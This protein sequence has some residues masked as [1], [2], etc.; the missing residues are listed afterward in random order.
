MVRLSTL[1]VGAGSGETKAPGPE[2]ET[3]SENAW[4][5]STTMATSCTAP[6]GA[7]ENGARKVWVPTSLTPE[8]PLGKPKVQEFAPE[9][10]TVSVAPVLQL[11]GLTEVLLPVVFT[12]T[13]KVTVE[14]GSK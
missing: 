7:E 13:T 11:I 3:V 14:P 9:D 12:E 4:F 1:S 2:I 8:A 6:S 10:W 5:C